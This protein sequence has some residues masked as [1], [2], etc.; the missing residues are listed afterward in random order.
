MGK[1]GSLKR[2]AQAKLASSKRK[3]SDKANTTF[4][5]FD[6]AAVHD[7]GDGVPDVSSSI[8]KDC[9]AQ[10]ASSWKLKAAAN[11]DS[12]GKENVTDFE[13]KRASTRS[14]S[15]ESRTY[16]IANTFC[17]NNLLCDFFMCRNCGSFNC[18]LGVTG[19]QGFASRLEVRCLSCNYFKEDYATPRIND[20][21]LKTEPFEIN[22]RMTLYSHEIGS[23]QAAL[24]KFSSSTGIQV[25]HL[26][27]FQ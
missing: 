3:L 17:L 21:E 20:S 18:E 24:E 13:E 11:V 15:I 27:T 22:R 2:R 4:E 19:H 14:S 26:K 6:R 23:S 9:N 16:F 1:N 25:M 10:S 12:S 8:L 5:T 7:H